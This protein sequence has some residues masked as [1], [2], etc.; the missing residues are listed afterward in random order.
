M[1]DDLNILVVEDEALLAV[2][3]SI[4]LEDEGACVTGPCFSL[5]SAMETSASAV[6]AAVLD[7]DLRGTPVFPLADRLAAE[8]KPFVFHTGRADLCE[9]RRRYGDDVPILIKPTRPEDLVRTLAAAVT[10]G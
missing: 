5:D 8:G 10:A 7:V 4:T 3:L 1:L 6:D 9:L 2:D